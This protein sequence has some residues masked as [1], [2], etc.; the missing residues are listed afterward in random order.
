VIELLKKLQ[1]REVYY[2]KMSDNYESL[3]SRISES[4]KLE[5]EEIERKVEAKRAKLSGLVSKEG[6]AQIVA[7]ELGINLD[8]EKLKISELVDGMKKANLVGKVIQIFPVREYSKNGREGKVCNMRV[9]DASGNT[10]VVLWDTNHISLIESGK[11]KEG[12]V[13]EI[14]NGGVRDGEIHLGGFSDIKKSKLKLDQVIEEQSFALRKLKDVKAGQQVK[15]RAFVVQ[16]FEPRYFEVCEQC[17]KKVVEGKCKEHGDVKSKKR[18]LLN[19]VLDD[20][21]ENIRSVL[22]GESIEKLGL[23]EEEI[24]DLDKFNGKKLSLMGEEKEFSGNVRN[25]SYSGDLELSLNGVEDVKAERLIKE[26][27]AKV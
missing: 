4:S 1:K 2:S 26:L 19:I 15:V 21:S 18:A 5:K 8:Q 17:G 23:T 24:F 10:R 14:S 22:F 25:N 16:V 3:L 9:G 20:G 7:A 13:L 12:D 27:E 6:A 11:I